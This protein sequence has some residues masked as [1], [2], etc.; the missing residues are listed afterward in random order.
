MPPNKKAI[1]GTHC[2]ACGTCIPICPFNA[3]S[4][5]NGITAIVDTNRCVGC[6]KCEKVCPAGIIEIFVEEDSINE[7]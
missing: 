2:V 6:G 4:I 5:P 7:N 3:I 1:I